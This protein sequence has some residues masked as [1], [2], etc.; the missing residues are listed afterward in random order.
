MC[1]SFSLQ[2]PLDEER[3][4][5][6]LWRWARHAQG[7]TFLQQALIQVSSVLVHLTATKRNPLYSV[8]VMLT[9]VFLQL[10][11]SI[12]SQRSHF[13]QAKAMN[14]S[15]DKKRAPTEPTAHRYSTMVRDIN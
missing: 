9:S 5:G 14:S 13:Y 8:G 10:I 12:I 3:N 7:V 11:C 15:L 4:F 1:Q 6:A 2:R